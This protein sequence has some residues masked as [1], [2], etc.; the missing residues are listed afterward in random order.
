MSANQ[1]RRESSGLPSRTCHP[2]S[3][4]C[5]TRQGTFR[6]RAALDCK[7]PRERGC[8]CWDAALAT[9]VAAWPARLLQNWMPWHRLLRLWNTHHTPSL[10]QRATKFSSCTSQQARHPRC[11]RQHQAR[12][13]TTLLHPPGQRCSL[14]NAA[15]RLPK[16]H[17]A[18][19][20]GQSEAPLPTR[21]CVHSLSTSGEQRLFN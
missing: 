3:V 4:Q 5:G 9:S 13:L 20:C 21:E 10:P 18:L 1:S 2:R 19:D 11:C 17:Q 8:Y 15:G 14:G 6:D 16:N 12:S 7:P